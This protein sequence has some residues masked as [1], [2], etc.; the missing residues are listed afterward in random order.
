MCQKTRSIK[1]FDSS[2]SRLYS[3]VVFITVNNKKAVKLFY[4]FFPCIKEVNRPMSSF[5]LIG[6]FRLIV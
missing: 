5:Q 4:G 1:S 6:R 3:I 2:R